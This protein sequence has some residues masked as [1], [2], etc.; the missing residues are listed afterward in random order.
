MLI[1]GTHPIKNGLKYIMTIPKHY[2][3]T[4]EQRK[5]LEPIIPPKT[6]VQNSWGCDYF[7]YCEHYLIEDFFNQMKNFRRFATRYDKLATRLLT[8]IYI[9]ATIALLK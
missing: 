6:N 2:E 9:C 5:R 3:L 8:T 7:T 4:D 1:S